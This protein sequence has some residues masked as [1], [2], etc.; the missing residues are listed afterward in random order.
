V[1]QCGQIL[2]K[3]GQSMCPHH[4]KC[5]QLH[6][7]RDSRQY[8]RHSVHVECCSV[9]LVHVLWHVS[10]CCTKCTSIKLGSSS[11]SSF[12]LL[13]LCYLWATWRLNVIKLWRVCPIPKDLSFESW[14]L[15]FHPI[16]TDISMSSLTE[17]STPQ[18]CCSHPSI[19]FLP[20]FPSRSYGGSHPYNSNTAPLPFNFLTNYRCWL[21]HLIRSV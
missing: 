12:S 18:Y 19:P 4:M 11:R 2:W 8:N 6:A 17:V 7:E 3:M 20:R 10:P 13:K 9:V 16:L 15:D 21:W 1:P 5:R 14:R